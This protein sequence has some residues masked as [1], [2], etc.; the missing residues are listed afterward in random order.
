MTR[1]VVLASERRV[2]RLVC[3]V[4]QHV[5]VDSLNGAYVTVQCQR[6]L[7]LV[8][9][10]AAVSASGFAI[11]SSSRPV[12]TLG[13]ADGGRLAVAVVTSMLGGEPEVVDLLD[14]VARH[15]AA[16]ASLA[17]LGAR[18]SLRSEWAQ[19]AVQAAAR[20]HEAAVLDGDR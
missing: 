18:L 8:I 6:C 4:R 19:E 3:G 9:F 17:F 11:G 15:P 1:V 14:E 7:E 10:G 2:R 12:G 5:W 16:V 20:E 13:D